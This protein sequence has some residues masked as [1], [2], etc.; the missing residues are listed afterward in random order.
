MKEKSKL[1]GKKYIPS[2]IKNNLFTNIYG[3]HITNEKDTKMQVK[4]YVRHADPQLYGE[5]GLLCRRLN[6]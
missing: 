6:N 2:H 3:M 1:V 4:K 5:F